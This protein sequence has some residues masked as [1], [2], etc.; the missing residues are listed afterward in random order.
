MGMLEQDRGQLDADSGGSSWISNNK[1]RLL[2]VGIVMVLTLGFLISQAFPGSTRYYLTV[3]EFLADSQSQDGRSVR[4]V[5]SLVPDSF[6][7]EQGTTLANF[8]IANEGQVLDASYQGVV[9][10]LFFNVDSEIVLE[11]KYNPNSGFHVDSV[12]VKCPSK[13]EALPQEV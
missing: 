8:Q 3:D 13:Y 4:V 7:R 12:V 10:D 9:P 1:V 11:G 2:L 6:Q 5:G